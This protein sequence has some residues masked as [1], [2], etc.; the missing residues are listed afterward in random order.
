[1][2]IEFLYASCMCTGQLGCQHWGLCG[3]DIY[4]VL[5]N[6]YY[7]SMS[8]GSLPSLGVVTV[9]NHC[10]S[11][12]LSILGYFLPMPCCC[13]VRVFSHQCHWPNPVLVPIIPLVPLSHPWWWAGCF[14]CYWGILPQFF[15]QLHCTMV[16]YGRLLD[17]FN[18]SLPQSIAVCC[19]HNCGDNPHQDIFSGSSLSEI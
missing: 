11:V 14:H 3:A 13:H 5:T 6:Y 12:P 17:Q 19:A 8:S 10:P 9:S 4:A 15:C 7:F 1:M 2:F 18:G 16:Y